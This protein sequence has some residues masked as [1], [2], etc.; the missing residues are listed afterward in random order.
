[1]W[2]KRTLAYPIKKL[3]EGHYVLHRFEMAP[4]GTGEI[5]RLLRYNENVLRYL[6]IRLDED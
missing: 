1:M 4:N 6:L 3:F 5:D 2:G